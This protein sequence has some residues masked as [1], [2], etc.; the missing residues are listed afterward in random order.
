MTCPRLA[1]EDLRH[2]LP[3]R[4]GDA[5]EPHV[6]EDLSS[7]DLPAEDGGGCLG[8]DVGIPGGIHL[9]PVGFGLLQ[10]L[11]HRGQAHGDEKGVHLED[12]LGSGDGPETII[13]AADHHPLDPVRS[14]GPE[15]GVSG[16]DRNTKA[17]DLVEVHPVPPAFGEGLH[18]AEHI[19][20]R[21]K[22]VVGCDETHVP[23][24]HHEEALRGPDQIPVHHGLEGPGP[25]HPGEIASR[26]GKGLLPCPGR[27]QESP[28]ADQNEPAIPHHPD[29]PVR[30]HTHHRGVQPDLH[31]LA[32]QEF[33]GEHRPDVHAPDTGIAL[34]CRSEEVVGLETQFAPRLALVIGD[35]HPDTLSRQF[36]GGGDACRPGS[37]DEHLDLHL[38]DVRGG[39]ERFIILGQFGQPHHGHD[40]HSLPEGGDAGFHGQ[41]VRKHE[42][43]GALPVCAEDPLRGAVPMMSAEDADAV[44]EQCGGDHLP[45]HG[46]HLLSVEGEPYLLTLT[47]GKD[48]MRGDAVLTHG[49]HP[50]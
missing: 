20:A 15:D 42:A 10:H 24:P 31:G 36:D 23:A 43:L 17:T 28:G 49:A 33:P 44:G 16:P 34:P 13:D 5:F 32:G 41:S 47:G 4:G 30:E 12:S 35:D 8:D 46:T 3:F 1:P 40:P 26:K 9:H 19:H 50:R 37:H 29:L 14:L 45:L 39:G 6:P 27:H 18:D 25:V 22:G 21:L 2:V 7:H 48:G 38:G 11:V